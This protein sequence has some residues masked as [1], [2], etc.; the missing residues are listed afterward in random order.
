MEEIVITLELM[1]CL[2]ESSES[3]SS[4]EDVLL[5]IAK[6]HVMPHVRCE[7]YVENVVPLYTDKEFQMHFR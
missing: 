3:D 2:M 1:K 4:D 6:P 5:M 7:N